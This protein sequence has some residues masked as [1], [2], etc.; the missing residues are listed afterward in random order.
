MNRKTQIAL[1]LLFGAAGVAAFGGIAFAA[2]RPKEL[3][4][5]SPPAIPPPQPVP[6]PIQPG[7][8]VDRSPA[9]APITDEQRRQ[10]EDDIVL[11]TLDKIAPGAR[12]ATLELRREIE[13]DPLRTKAV[14]TRYAKVATAL[15]E[16]LAGVRVLAQQ[17]LLEAK[18]IYN[19]IEQADLF[20]NII[21][22]IPVIGSVISGLYRIAR[23]FAIGAAQAAADGHSE[24][25]S[26]PMPGEAYFF[27]WLMAPDPNTGGSPPLIPPGD[28]WALNLP[29]LSSTA[30]LQGAQY[31]AATGEVY[32][33][34]LRSLVRLCTAY[35]WGINLP[36]ID[37]GADGMY[38]Y[39]FNATGNNDLSD[40]AN[41]AGHVF[42]VEV[43][44]VD[45]ITPKGPR[46]FDP[47]TP[48]AW[49]AHAKA[50][51]LG[52]IGSSKKPIPATDRPGGS[53]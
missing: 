36:R 42:N 30:A 18:G 19:K 32:G 10:A 11:R 34:A 16:L 33:A 12:A 17:N 26:N 43:W 25:G 41:Q 37:I 49:Y 46:E 3:A 15:A 45:D 20:F 4:G 53:Y 6:L 9:D 7:I 27:G 22:I 52:L 5:G 47:K 23:P 38:R 31:L 44:S 35:P 1:T 14:L 50:E 13:T 48:R 40:A 2:T 8:Q 39:L 51:A 24:W 21:N 29:V 28:Y